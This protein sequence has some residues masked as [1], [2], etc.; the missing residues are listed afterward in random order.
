MDP[1]ALADE[2]VANA[3]SG[4]FGEPHMLE[5][6][7]LRDLLGAFETDAEISAA[8]QVF[9]DRLEELTGYR[10][11]DERLIEPV[12]PQQST[13]PM[14]PVLSPEELARSLIAQTFSAPF[15]GTEERIEVFASRARGSVAELIRNGLDRSYC[16]AI[17][18]EMK[19]E[20]RT[21]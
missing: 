21:A 13:I 1:K 17:I 7:G 18:E 4:K 10:A 5:I 6:Q 16:E 15:D 14:P 8:V 19:A 11:P 9:Q 2:L 12:Q 3:P 20:L